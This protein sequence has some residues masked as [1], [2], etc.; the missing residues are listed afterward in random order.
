MWPFRTEKN[1]HGIYYDYE[2]R[3]DGETK[4]TADPYAKACGINGRRSM[5]VDLSL[6]NPIG[7]GKRIMPRNSLRNALFTRCM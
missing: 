2:I 5:G 4:R 1:L 3:I 7:G 6:T